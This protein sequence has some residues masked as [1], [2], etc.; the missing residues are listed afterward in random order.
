MIR[1]P[2]LVEGCA[3]WMRHERVSGIQGV[4]LQYARVRI[5]WSMAA[6]CQGMAVI[7]QNSCN[8]SGYESTRST[9]KEVN[10]GFRNIG[11]GV[12]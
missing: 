11:E 9:S 5:C 10:I 12:F 3:M 1:K 6:I 4:W 8:L 2:S 7:C